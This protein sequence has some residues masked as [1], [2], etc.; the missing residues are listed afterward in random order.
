MST[1]QRQRA[2]WLPRHR[3][4]ASLAAVLLLGAGIV[5]ALIPAARTAVISAAVTGWTLPGS[6]DTPG[7]A[8]R[9]TPPDQLGQV[10]AATPS[11]PRDTAGSLPATP[12]TPKPGITWQLQASGPPDVSAAVQLFDL[13]LFDTTPAQVA[14]VHAK[15]A[16]AICSMSTGVWQA[17]RPDAN[18]FPSWLFGRTVGGYADQRYLDLRQLDTL[19]PLVT[20]RLRLCRAKGF[21][22]VDPRGDDTFVD[23]GSDDVGVRLSYADQ[24]A[25]DRMVAD[26]AHG[27]GLSIGLRT[28]T[29][30]DAAGQFITDL[31]PLTDFAVNE[32]CAAADQRCTPL[33]RFIR[34]GKA[35]LHVE[36]LTD[37]PGASLIAF[38]P[39]L[40][41]FCPAAHEL[42]FS[43]ILKAEPPAPPA[44][45]QPCV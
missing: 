15:G 31:E 45:R 36:Y 5:V 11:G 32:R 24:L 10:V 27:L 13:D 42:G 16:H 18:T 26:V 2:A 14:A 38:A 4:I 20:A 44:W 43:S 22:G 41:R 29:F 28:G 25:F 30:G 17:K 9:R 35:V 21:D 23:A 40:D 33:E 12:W 1:R 34:K 3:S 37:Y 39:A 7:P 8:V 19:R 6:T